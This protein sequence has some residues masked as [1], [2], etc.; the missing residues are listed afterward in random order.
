MAATANT[1]NRLRFYNGHE[2]PVFGPAT[3]AQVDDAIA[4]V[5]GGKNN[6]VSTEI[7]V[8]ADGRQAFTTATQPSNTS[9]IAISLPDANDGQTFTFTDTP[10]KMRIV[11]VRVMRTAAGHAANTYVISSAQASGGA[12]TAVTNAIAPDA[13]DKSVA[14]AGTIDDASMDVAAGGEIR[15]VYAKNSNSMACKIWITVL[16]VA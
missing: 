9:V 4:D 1:G 2:P 12:F 6:A 15:V 7:T 5:L 14:G 11:D 10:F 13:G 16:R 3:K 8:A